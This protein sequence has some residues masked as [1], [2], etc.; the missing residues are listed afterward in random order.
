MIEPFFVI[1]QTCRNRYEFGIDPE[2]YNRWRAGEYAQN[3]FPYL[4]DDQ[5]ELLVSQTCGSC[6]DRMFPEEDDDLPGM[7]A[8]S[9]LEG[10]WADTEG[11]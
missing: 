5:R 9:D 7:W 4:T 10:G 11:R 6:F 8:R 3:A 2:D 1:C